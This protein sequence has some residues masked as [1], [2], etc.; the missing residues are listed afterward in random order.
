MREI[1]GRIRCSG[2]FH[3]V[4]ID[5]DGHPFTRH[6]DRDEILALKVAEKMSGIEI[7]VPCIQFLRAIETCL[8]GRMPE[9]RE[10][11]REVENFFIK[12]KAEA[13]AR[14]VKERRLER[15]RVRTDLRKT[16]Y[17][18]RTA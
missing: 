8:K 2:T 7:D 6:H 3:T 14:R 1:K 18:W 11:P 16:A 9:P 15:A 12:R 5:R 10:F 13:V 17:E 4:G